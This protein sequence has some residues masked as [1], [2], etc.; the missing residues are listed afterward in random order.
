MKYIFLLTVQTSSNDSFMIKM[1]SS[2]SSKVAVAVNA[3]N[4]MP[5]EATVVH[6]QV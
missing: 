4:D 1:I 3:I 2:L 5:G 6:N